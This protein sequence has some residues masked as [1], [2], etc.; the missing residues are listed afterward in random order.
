[1]I[2]VQLLSKCEQIYFELLY[3]KRKLGQIL[4]VV[5]GI[6]YQKGPTWILV[7]FLSLVNYLMRYKIQNCIKPKWCV[8]TYLKFG[9]FDL[10]RQALPCE[11]FF[12]IIIVDCFIILHSLHNLSPIDSLGLYETP[13]CTSE[14]TKKLT[15][16]CFSV[17][18]LKEYKVVGR[19]LPSDKNRTPPLYQMRI[20]APD[21]CTA[22]S[23]FWYFVSQLKKMKKMSGEILLCQQ[24]IYVFLLVSQF[25]ILGV[26]KSL[27][28]T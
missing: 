14:K 18:Q 22:K 19:S 9:G 2:Y 17:I 25:S 6:I 13:T 10:C 15:H 28:S 23:R 21:K 1:M 26:F 20:F 12:K 4:G 7:K 11:A 27:V 5:T 24:V 16:E 8:D 3:Q